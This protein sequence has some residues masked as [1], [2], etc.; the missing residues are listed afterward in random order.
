MYPDRAGFMDACCMCPLY[1]KETGQA[2]ILIF[3][4][5]F[6]YQV[7]PGQ[8]HILTLVGLHSTMY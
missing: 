6:N 8:A 4:F 7:E 3:N 5:F 1:D 2:H